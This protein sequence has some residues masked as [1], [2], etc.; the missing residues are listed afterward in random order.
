MLRRHPDGDRSGGTAVRCRTAL[1]GPVVSTVAGGQVDAAST[2]VGC[3]ELACHLGQMVRLDRAQ[4]FDQLA[5]LLLERGLCRVDQP[6]PCS[7][8]GDLDATAIGRI[9]PTAYRPPLCPPVHEPRHARLVELEEVGELVDRECPVPQDPEKTSLGDRD[10]V[11]GGDPPED[12]LHREAELGQ[13]IHYPEVRFTWDRREDVSSAPSHP[14]PFP[15]TLDGGTS[16]ISAWH[17]LS[18][19]TERHSTGSEK[20]VSMHAA[21]VHS[22]D[23]PPNY[24]IHESPRPEPGKELVEVLAVGLHPRVRSGASGSHYTST[25]ALPMIPGIDGVGRL[26]H[27]ES[28][29]FVAPDD[30]WGTMAERALADPRRM[31]PIPQSANPSKVAAA[32]NPAMSSWVAFRRRVP[33]QQGQS[34]LV[35]GATGNAGA[36]ATRT[37]KLLGA[38]K[39]VGAGR[40]KE[41]LEA[42][43]LGGVDETVEITDDPAAT[44]ERL[45]EAAAD[46][47]IVVD[48]L[49]GE[50]AT[51]AIPALLRAREDRSRAL[52][53]IQI[54]AVT[55]PTIELPSVALRSTNLRIQ[56]VGQGSVSPEVYLGELPSLIDEI[57]VGS[58]D[59]EIHEVPLA[60]VETVWN[61]DVAPGVRT[62][63]IP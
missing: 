57:G 2:G 27:G 13:G 39:I 53:W 19:R 16:Y 7:R 24:E 21:V 51:V 42:L 11:L 56:G 23:S 60:E 47:D 52:D 41:R 32:M 26:S 55:G 50:I 35:L 49:W 44:S 38:G 5:E 31:I 6:A 22:F 48:Y 40:N 8:D 17:Q 62:V 4:D 45:A 43:S 1:S 10:I 28:V 15:D 14:R 18:P 25:G 46:V 20:A 63:F 33:L 34:V 12:S 58:I 36:M 9:S 30:T 54:G 3:D 29:Y 37:A 61:H 59:V